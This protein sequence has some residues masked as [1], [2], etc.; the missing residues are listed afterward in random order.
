MEM[1]PFDVIETIIFHIIASDDHQSQNQTLQAC[2]L[3]CQALRPLCQREIFRTVLIR[4]EKTKATLV[5][6]VQD[7]QHTPKFFEYVHKLEYLVE[8]KDLKASGPTSIVALLKN[9]TKIRSFVLSFPAGMFPGYLNDW[10]RLPCYMRSIFLSLM[11]LPTI[12]SIELNGN[13]INF[14]HFVL[15]PCTN[16]KELKLQGI[17]FAAWDISPPLNTPAKSI[18]LHRLEMCYDPTVHWVK[19]A[20]DPYYGDGKSTLDLQELKHIT[21]IAAMD[22]SPVVE[23]FKKTQIL[24]TVF[25]DFRYRQENMELISPMIFASLKTLT[26]LSLAFNGEFDNVYVDVLSSIRHILQGI[27]GRNVISVLRVIILDI[28]LFLMAT[29]EIEKWGIF[30]EILLAPGWP[31]LAEFDLKVDCWTNGAATDQIARLPETQLRGLA[32]MFL[33]KLIKNFPLKISTMEMV[34]FDII[35]TIIFHIIASDDHQSRNQTLQ[36]CALT[37]QALR[38][39]CQRELFRTVLIRQE[40]TK[41]TLVELVQDTQHTPKFFE[42]VHKLEYLVERK[43][44][45]ASGPTPIVA[46]LKN[47]TKIRSFVLSFQAEMFPGYFNDWKKLPPYMQSIFLSLMHLP[48]ITSIELYG[49]LINFDHFVLLPCTNLRELRLQGI[50]FA[51]W[52]KPPPLNTPAESIKLHRLEMC[53]DPTV[54]WVK[55]TLDPYYEDGTSTLDLREL[56]H[57]TLEAAT[58]LSLVAE[59]FKKTRVLETVFLNFKYHDENMEL[60]SPMIFTSLKTLTTLSLTLNSEFEMFYVDVLSSIRHILQG[61]AGRNVISVLRV[62]LDID[63]FLVDPHNIEE[64]GIFD[65]IL[66]APGWPSL[67]EFDLKVN[68]SANEAGRGGGRLVSGRWRWRWRGGKGAREWRGRGMQEETEVKGSGGSTE[69]DWEEIEGGGQTKIQPDAKIA[70]RLETRPTPE[71][72]SS[73]ASTPPPQHPIQHRAAHL[74]HHAHPERA[75]SPSSSMPIRGTPS[76]VPSARASSRTTP[77]R[78]SSGTYLQRTARRSGGV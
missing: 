1:V 38:P 14:D 36:A 61:I 17:C 16:L 77:P 43:D 63:L 3:T 25:L 57:I 56:K 5:E 74:L 35:E 54:H 71:V 34:P 33:T 58:D 46:L 52:D 59:I 75:S 27:T 21:L 42:Y 64:W 7:T 39:L 32:S 47:F 29:H 2:A 78:A 48:T 20:L 4:Q 37:C 19:K 31:S 68:L 6:L 10:K 69:K 28:D 72:K 44:L 24:E 26:N 53:Y 76:L 18:K 8:R 70:K 55:N 11:H 13:L 73:T 30:D 15:L 65:E 60:I 51:A 12:T 41:A 22:L 50:A 45:K 49:S 40:K 67:A 66:L 9:F 23:I 62:I